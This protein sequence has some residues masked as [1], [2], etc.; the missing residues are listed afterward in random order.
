M[1]VSYIDGDSSRT[2]IFTVNGTPVEAPLPGTNDND[3]D[4]PQTAVVPVTLNAGSNS[5]QLGNANGY[6]YDLDKI[7]L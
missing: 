5:I 2:G 3:W 6:V 7:V 1:T 4:T